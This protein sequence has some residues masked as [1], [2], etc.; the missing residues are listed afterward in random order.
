MPKCSSPAQRPPPGLPQVDSF[1]PPSSAAM[2]SS[3][4]AQE[5]A[6]TAVLLAAA[7]SEA[8]DSQIVLRS[9][10]APVEVVANSVQSSPATA[11]SPAHSRARVAEV[12]CFSSVVPQVPVAIVDSHLARPSSR[13]P[14]TFP[15]VPPL[16]HAAVPTPSDSSLLSQ[17]KSMMDQM[18]QRS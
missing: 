1:P 3:P 11:Q 8:L 16:P 18:L 14:R 12:S 2:A 15:A 10:S 5:V 4:T 6:Q 17:M 7:A 9:D 13:A